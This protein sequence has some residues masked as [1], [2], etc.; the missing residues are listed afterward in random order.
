P[1]DLDG[2]GTVGAGDLAILLSAWGACA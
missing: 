2:D 1:A